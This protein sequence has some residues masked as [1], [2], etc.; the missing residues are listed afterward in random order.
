MKLQDEQVL[1]WQILYNE[2]YQQSATGFDP[3]LNFVGW[4]SSYTNQ[5]IPLEQ[6]SEWINNQVAQILDLQPQRVL[7]IGCGT[8]LV[9]FRV[10]PHCIQ[11]C[12]TDFSQFSLNYIRHQLAKQ[13]IPQV[14]LHQKMAD[15]FEG[16]ETGIFDVVILNSVVQYFPSIDYFIHV[17]EG[18]VKATAPGGSI[19]IGDVRNLCLLPA[20]HASVQIYQAE[21]SLTSVELQQR[22]QLQIF[23]EEE[24]VIDPTFFT[25]I[26]QIFPQISHVQIQ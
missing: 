3:T 22:T 12:A 23:Q 1:Q 21:P 15:D 26:K 8:G 18:A 25:A 11:Y 2:V 7:E 9:L 14:T 17:L 19:F 20:F 5:S 10:A 6:M 16:I 24:L 13:E 4:N